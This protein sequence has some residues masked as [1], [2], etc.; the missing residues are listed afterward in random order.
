M[1]HSCLYLRDGDLNMAWSVQALTSFSLLSYFS[2]FFPWL[3]LL[4]FFRSAWD[5]S[6]KSCFILCS[7]WYF[8]NVAYGRTENSITAA[9]QSECKVLGRQRLVLQGLSLC[10][11]LRVTAVCVLCT[12]MM[13][14]SETLVSGVQNLYDC[15]SLSI[16]NG[17]LHF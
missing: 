3:F 1:K 7:I 8:L 11:Y 5:L 10:L 12:K 9:T 4:S 16:S 15:L 13:Y 14:D 6:R 2:A 17:K